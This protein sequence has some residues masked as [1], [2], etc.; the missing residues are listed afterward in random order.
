MTGRAR[1]W[2]SL[3]GPEAKLDP[4]VAARLVLGT[5]DPR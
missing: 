4:D 3:V 1:A 2:R 5:P